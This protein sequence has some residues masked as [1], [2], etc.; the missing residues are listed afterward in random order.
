MSAVE[1][2]D[3]HP[4]PDRRPGHFPVE[5]KADPVGLGET[6]ARRRDENRSVEERQISRMNVVETRHLSRPPRVCRR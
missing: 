2:A 3:A 5:V 6:E 1:M 4:V